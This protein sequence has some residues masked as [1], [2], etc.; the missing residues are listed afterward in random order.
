MQQL[1]IGLDG[2]SRKE[3]WVTYVEELLVGLVITIRVAN[4][5]QEVVLLVEDVVT[6]TGQVGELHVGVHVDL[7][8]TEADGLEVLLLGGARA[9]VEDEEDGLVVLGLDGGLDVG[10][11]LAEQLG[12]EL[13]VAGLVDTVDV[14]E[15]SGNGEV[16]GDGGEG[17]VDVEDVL[18]LGVEGVVV[19]I[20][21]VDT[22][23]L[24]TSDANLH[25]EPLLHGSSAL[26]VLGGG[27]DVPVNRLLGQIN[28]VRREEGLAGS[29]E[30]GLIS[31]E[32]A[33]EPREELLGAVV[34]VEDDGNAVGG[35]NGSDVVGTGD[36][37]GDGGSL[38]SVVDTLFAS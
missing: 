32:H 22:V 9:A 37:T 11:V 29:L 36:G 19:D 25:L 5:S 28:H 6:D 23:L 17:V 2:L 12:V 31:S 38:V 16:G 1:A 4:G 13:D 3:Q 26:Q 8:D 21:V 7:D 10:L 34:G 18:G 20:L 33:I 30:V 24:T 27:L 14:A 35:G 15:A